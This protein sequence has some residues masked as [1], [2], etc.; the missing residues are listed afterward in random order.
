MLYKLNVPIDHRFR[1]L[2]FR[3]IQLN[4]I[5]GRGSADLVDSLVE[6]IPGAGGD[7]TDRPGVPAYIV[8]GHKA[9]VCIRGI[10]IDQFTVVIDPIS[11]S[12]EGR[13]SLGRSRI[14]IALYHM[15]TEFLQNV[16]EMDGG[17]L[18]AFNGD[19]LRGR[20]HIAVNR[21]FCHKISAG[22]ELLFNLPVFP[23]CYILIDFIP[24]KIRTGNVEG[25]PG[26]NAVLAGLDKFCGA[27]GFCL[28]FYKK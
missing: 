25:N 24:K 12:G 22:K 6:Q 23:G 3:C 5:Q 7:F 9:A 4:L 21:D 11:C 26:H 1:D 27:I 2:A 14:C 18:A 15:D 13:V 28:D 20:C 8:T 17:S 16:A 10:G 19:I